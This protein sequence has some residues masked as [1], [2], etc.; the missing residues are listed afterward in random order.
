MP[1]RGVCVM[2]SMVMIHC[3]ETGKDVSTGILT[4]SISFERLRNERAWVSCPACR[5]TH[6]WIVLRPW[7]M[8]V[9]EPAEDKLP[10]A[11]TATASDSI[12][13]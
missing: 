5:Q 11:L 8:E 12:I 2:S 3:P 13:S 9:A 1:S 4:D 10:P 6:R 7:L